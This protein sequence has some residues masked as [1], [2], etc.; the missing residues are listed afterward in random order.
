[1]SVL[2]GRATREERGTC[3]TEKGASEIAGKGSSVRRYPVRKNSSGERSR[4]V[5]RKKSLPRDLCGG[6]IAQY[7][8]GDRILT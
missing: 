5:R 3:H 2:L 4:C 8:G 1:M 6:K 7:T